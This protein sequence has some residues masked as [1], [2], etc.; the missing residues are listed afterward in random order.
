[1]STN[2]AEVE[3]R[4]DWVT[5]ALVQFIGELVAMKGFT[6]ARQV[7][8]HVVNAYWDGRLSGVANP[9]L[10]PS[11][12]VLD[13]D[14]RRPYTFQEIELAMMLPKTQAYIAAL[15]RELE[16]D[17]EQERREAR[18]SQL[19]EARRI[20][21][22]KAEHKLVPMLFEE[23]A[24]AQQ[25]I[26]WLEEQLTRSVVGAGKPLEIEFVLLEVPQGV[27]ESGE[28]KG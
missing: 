21:R 7:G 28:L 23:L 26:E 13:A 6:S 27:E 2:L 3:T 9:L 14:K 4:L 19:A 22:M 17:K 11:G 18:V 12:D 25:K 20:K 15:K 10:S 24:K 16:N 1:M 8:P 5:D